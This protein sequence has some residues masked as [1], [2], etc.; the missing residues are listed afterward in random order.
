MASSLRPFKT[1]VAVLFGVAATAVF[2]AP[3][4]VRAEDLMAPEMASRVGLV[5]NWRRQ[6]SLIG[7]AKSA[8]DIQLHV[9][10]NRERHF[11]EVTRE[12]DG[13]VEVL[14]RRDVNEL[15][16][17]G[18]PLGV[19]EARRLASLEVLRWRRRGIETKLA[20]N[21]IRQV[22]LYTLGSDGTIEARDAET[23]ELYWVTRNGD[24]DLFC[25]SMGIDDDY[26]TFINGTVLYQLSAETGKLI[27]QTTL[28]GTPSM[29]SVIAGE[30][31]LVPTVRGGIE[32]FPLYD[33]DMY[34]FHEIVAGHATA[35]PVRAPGTTRTAWATDLR[36]VYVMETEGTPSV[37]FRFP[38]D[39]IV[40]SELAAA[41]GNRFFFGSENGHVYGIRATRSGEVLWR[42]SIGQPIYSTA[43][44]SGERLFV[45]SVYKNLYCL[46]LATGKHFWKGPVSQI[47]QVLGSSEDHIF[48][49][50][51]SNRLT[52]I[53][54]ASGT[55]V[56]D[57]SQINLQHFV[58]NRLTDRL[59][60]I[61]AGGMLQC[62][63][64]SNASLP[65]FKVAAEITVAK[66]SDSSD[67]EPKAAAG[68]DPFGAN[69]NIDPFDAGGAAVDP[70][71]PAGDMADP[72]APAAGGADPFAPAGGGA[73]PFG[74][75]PFQN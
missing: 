44:V 2:P 4:S 73:D 57:V 48:A 35:K 52:V 27:R 67:S 8:V 18:K 56:A 10:G 28:A 42:Q 12:K 60:L 34:P 3:A 13:V 62:L 14:S 47:D 20:E 55:R 53:N 26:V 51:N 25:G 59:Y 50:T 30:F 68:N 65:T 19:K 5:E 74:G 40:S 46:E 9:E 22:R 36:F 15:D 64:P 41:E 37:I 70:F 39:G 75:D 29:G 6:L 31:A 24:P 63:R 71:A 66:S 16:K 21:K 32:G 17:Y 43:F 54:A 7:G 72:F 33:S 38:T 58:T 11:V 1:F 49:R 45:S 69:G 61:G 23:G